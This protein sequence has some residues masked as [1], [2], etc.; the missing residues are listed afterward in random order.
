MGVVV[1]AGTTAELIK[2]APVLKAL[3]EEGDGYRFWNTAWHVEGL[4]ATLDDLRED[5]PGDEDLRAQPLP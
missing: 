3:R 2:L 4:R 1:I 5:S